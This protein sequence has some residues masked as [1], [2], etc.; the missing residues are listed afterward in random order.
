MNYKSKLN[1]IKAIVFDVDGV[2]TD[3]SV[4][5]LPDGN[6]SRSMNTR[7][8]YAMQLAVKMNY[9]VGIITG[10]RDMGVV[11]RLNNLGITDIYT[12]SHNKIEDFK[13]F[14]FKYHLQASE[15][16]YMGD[17]IPDLE[18]MKMC[19][20]PCCPKDAAP[21]IRKISLYISQIQGGKGCVRDIIEQL[22][23]VQGNWENDTQTT[24]I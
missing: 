14:L 17:D 24:S 9:P 11:S 19:G 6:M 10:G 5:I 3:G 16:L 8:G 21:E 7:D 4:L 12:G 22:L 18:V 23:K 13:D 2:L 20:L 1:E 15:V